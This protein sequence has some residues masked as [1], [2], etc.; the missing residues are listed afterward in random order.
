VHEVLVQKN[1]SVLCHAEVGVIGTGWFYIFF[2]LF[3]NFGVYS[4]LLVCAY[5]YSVAQFSLFKPWSEKV[6]TLT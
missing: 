3:P 1:H 4:K 6:L 5:W 2:E